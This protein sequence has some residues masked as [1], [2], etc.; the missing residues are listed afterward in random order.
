MSVIASAAPVATRAAH[1]RIAVRLAR[2]TDGLAYDD[3]ATWLDNLAGALGERLLRLKG[4]VRVKES[5]RPML[6]QCVGTVFA[7]PRP[8]GEPQAVTPE[9]LVI[10]ARDLQAAE[11][12]AVPPPG[13]F[14][15]SSWT[16]PSTP[17]LAGPLSPV[18]VAW[19]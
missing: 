5:E 16:E 12:E 14:T 2:P 6:V 3:L 10:I 8:F 1:A 17:Q 11:L 15:Y 7:P 9:F 18:S 13:L 4:L 19:V